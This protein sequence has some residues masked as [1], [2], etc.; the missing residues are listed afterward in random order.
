MQNP[1]S[2]ASPEEITVWSAF[3]ERT[4]LSAYQVLNIGHDRVLAP[5]IDAT[6]RDQFRLFTM[7]FHPDRI[8]A[9]HPNLVASATR[10]TQKV[11]QARF[12]VQ[13][14]NRRRDYNIS[15][16]LDMGL[17]DGTFGLPGSINSAL[18]RGAYGRVLVA[19][20]KL[21]AFDLRLPKVVVVGLESSGKSST[22]ERLAM[23]SAFP[24][25]EAFTTR[26]PIAMKLRFR[27]HENV[28]TVRHVKILADGNRQQLAER[29]I[30]PLDLPAGAGA[31]QDVVDDNQIAQLIQEAIAAAHPGDRGLDVLVDEEIEIEIRAPN[32]PDLDLIDLPGI[33]AMPEHVRASTISCTQRY[34]RD[35]NT[36]V[37]CVIASPAGTVR[38]E[39]EM[40]R[41]IEEEARRAPAARIWDRT[42]LVL[43]KVDLQPA[44]LE[45]RL[46]PGEGD[47]V[48]I[49]ATYVVPVINRAQDSGRSIRE[50]LSDELGWFNRWCAGRRFSA[51]DMGIPGVLTHLSRLVDAHI[52]NAWVPQEVR[53]LTEQLQ[54]LR[55]ELANLGS[56]AMAMGA[57]GLM[58]LV[59]VEVLRSIGSFVDDQSNAAAFAPSEFAPSEAA[60]EGLATPP[61]SAAELIRRTWAVEVFLRDQLGPAIV[62]ATKIVLSGALASAAL[63][64]RLCRFEGL[65]A[66]LLA[67]VDGSRALRDAIADARALIHTRG[68]LDDTS[69]WQSVHVEQPHS[70]GVP[71][72]G[73]FVAPA[74]PAA[75]AA[76]RQ[77]CNKGAACKMVVVQHCLIKCLRAGGELLSGANIQA[78]TAEDSRTVAERARLR[79]RIRLFEQAIGVLKAVAAGAAAGGV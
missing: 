39:A 19:V 55:Q 63:P 27:R 76:T 20:S 25:G 2:P 31:T 48:G 16:G 1:R 17:G 38:G 23:R 33:V 59:A 4:D 13:D 15:V 46:T 64:H 24:R 53:R 62:H 26:M 75:P 47:L 79:E 22:L 71:G 70:A 77:H 50:A 9:A 74:P 30:E 18:L 11:T 52:T 61:G 66:Q 36:L 65:R 28:V 49:P 3:L 40:A 29:V 5:D 7:A 57:A 12:T 43:S 67:R 41:I 51:D 58:E 73:L 21:R 54:P 35:P 56:D 78:A 8:A 6:I 14:E 37:L 32:V 44:R 42:I 72:S 60:F 68:Y 34:L 69:S 10:I 45:A